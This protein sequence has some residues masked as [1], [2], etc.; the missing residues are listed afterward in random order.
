MAAFPRA[1]YV[2]TVSNPPTEKS[3]APTDKVSRKVANNTRGEFTVRDA[4]VA[5]YFI[6]GLVDAAYIH[7]CV[8]YFL[9]KVKQVGA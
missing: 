3:D 1:C 2:Q 7:R 9:A 4:F 6:L 8:L 5:L